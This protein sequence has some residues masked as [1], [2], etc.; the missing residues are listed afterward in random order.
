MSSSPPEPQRPRAR[1]GGRV[2]G[3]SWEGRASTLLPRIAACRAASDPEL[4]FIL[5]LQLRRYRLS[6]CRCSLAL[7][8]LMGQF[9]QA[10]PSK[11][12]TDLPTWTA[13]DPPRPPQCE[14]LP[15]GYFC[16][17]LESS[18]ISSKT[19]AP[20]LKAFLVRSVVILMNVIFGYRTMKCA[21]CM[22]W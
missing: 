21:D 22:I 14:G 16:L 17:P 7:Y 15:L 12:L 10:K 11:H 1:R 9:F 18:Q 3:G 8:K 4:L 5:A 19:T 20:F 6:N 2:L 13:R